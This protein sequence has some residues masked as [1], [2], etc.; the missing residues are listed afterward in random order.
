MDINT[1][2][3]QLLLLFVVAL[4]LSI[5][6]AS[7]VLTGLVFLWIARTNFRDPTEIAPTFFWPLSLYAI[8]TLITVIFSVDPMT[9]L[10]E[11]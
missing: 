2:N 1:I 5:A 4:P 9:S 11:S 7:I 10:G 3:W 6:A 8:W